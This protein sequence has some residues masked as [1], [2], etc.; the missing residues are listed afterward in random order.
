MKLSVHDKNPKYAGL[1]V[2]N[3]LKYNMSKFGRET[4]E[5]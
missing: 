2:G 5:V 1:W 4:F 3:T